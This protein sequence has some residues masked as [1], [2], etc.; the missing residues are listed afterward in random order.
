MPILPSRLSP[1]EIALEAKALDP[2]FLSRP[3][4]L[5]TSPLTLKFSVESPVPTLDV[6]P[7]SDRRTLTIPAMM[8]GRQA[9][10]AALQALGHL[11][12]HRD[13]MIPAVPGRHVRI[14]IGAEDNTDGPDGPLL[15]A[16]ARRYA[17]AFL[18]LNLPADRARE[19]QE[20]Y[21][22]TDEEMADHFDTA[23]KEDFAC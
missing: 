16:E 14:R 6:E 9:E 19:A 2:D 5:V 13:G 21:A 18:A 12:L 17:I 7:V 22:L 8:G 15:A 20:T 10:F 23:R 4:V 1:D 11:A 3:V